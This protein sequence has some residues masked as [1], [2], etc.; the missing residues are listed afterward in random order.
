MLLLSDINLNAHRQFLHPN[1]ISFDGLRAAEELE[2]LSTALVGRKGQE[3]KACA[4]IYKELSQLAE[5]EFHVAAVMLRVITEGCNETEQPLWD[6]NDLVRAI[7]C[8]A[9]EES[10]HASTFHGYVRALTG[11]DYKV[12][13]NLFRER[14]S[15]FSGDDPAL[16]KLAA[17]CATAY[18]GESVITVFENRL[19]SIDPGRRHHL[20]ELL[21]LHGLDEARHIHFDHWVFDHVIP[22]LSVKERQRM[23][24]MVEATEALNTQLAITAKDQFSEQFAVDF[25]EDN[26][27]AQVQLQMTLA[28][29]SAIQAGVS[30]RRVDEFITPETRSLIEKF[31]LSETVHAHAA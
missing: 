3:E 28:F 30:I 14:M 19:K 1:K 20:T 18:V 10:Q 29:R 31:S 23:A 17:L 13:D 24:E 15:I 26:L 27:S 7:A 2:F 22:S 25:C 4:Y 9:A 6:G 12:R 11:Q 16:V 8:F 21:H 5:I